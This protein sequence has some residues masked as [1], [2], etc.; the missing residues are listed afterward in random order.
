MLSHTR[1]ALYI[2]LAF[3][4]C[5]A[6]SVSK[7]AKG[8]NP[9]PRASQHHLVSFTCSIP[10]LETNVRAVGGSIDRIW[11]AIGVV[12]VSGLGSAD[13]VLL[14]KQ[15]GISVVERDI[16]L[17]WVEG[18]TP[19]KN[20]AV[21]SSQRE[22][23]SGDP[24]DAAFFPVQWNLEQ[25]NAE[26]G[27]NST[28]GHHNTRIGIL[29]T[30]I[31]PDHVDLRGRYDLTASINL[32]SSNPD[33]RSDYLDRHMQGTLLSALISSNSIGIASVAPDV[34]LVGIKI[35]NDEGRASISH[36]IDGLMYAAG[37]GNV[38]VINLSVDNGTIGQ[39]FTA[40]GE[41]F[42]VAVRHV[43]STGVVVVA[44]V[45]NCDQKDSSP[46]FVNSLVSAGALVVG[47][48]I[49]AVDGGY[50][51]VACYADGE[52]SIRLYAPGGAR[53]C[54]QDSYNSIDDMVISALSPET[55]RSMD[56]PSPDS[57]YV[58]SSGAGVSAAHVTGIAAL[59]RTVACDASPHYV[60]TQ[61]IR[62]VDR[63]ADSRTGKGEVNAIFAATR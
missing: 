16:E 41:M 56:L 58:F 40:L 27:W 59:V 57:W 39:E 36:I 23:A 10:Q 33:N 42:S 61:L 34:T 30:G 54:A 1:L 14:G 19:G 48:T 50:G 26:S 7:A 37:E 24:S 8:N 20:V 47:P 53:D 4:I 6:P 62:S 28:R 12:R 3:L 15:I 60:V 13:A 49:R 22:S 45:G 9:S 51:P 63:F 17:Q 46:T 43:I 31:S 52:T 44:S 2:C 5:L 32:S 11:D 55:A 18:F 21:Q 29:S 25:I 35:F 38:D